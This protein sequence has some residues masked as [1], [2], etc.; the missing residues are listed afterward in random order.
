[1]TQL[2]RAEVAQPRL[3]L[4]TV[5]N[6]AELNSPRLTEAVGAF[7][8]AACTMTAVC[9][10]SACQF[11][12]E[13]AQP[14]ATYKRTSSL[15]YGP[16][17]TLTPDSAPGSNCRFECVGEP[18]LKDALGKLRDGIRV[19]EVERKALIPGKSRRNGS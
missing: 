10:R 9:G 13:V 19:A 2:I 15:E 17:I 4:R 18:P 3:E 12:V 14:T 1:M 11:A 5:V 6:A 16:V 7:A 8:S